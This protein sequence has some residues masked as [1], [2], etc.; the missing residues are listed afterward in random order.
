MN[1]I[2]APNRRE[3][4]WQRMH[5]L[6]YTT[7]IHLFVTQGY[8]TTTMDQI[9]ER[10]DVARATV[11]N[12]FVQKVG[13][14]EEWGARRRVRVAEILGR[15]HAEDMPVDERLRRY[16]H[17]MAELNTCSREESMVLME[18][19]ARFGRLWQDPSLE[20]DLANII[21]VGV[22]RGEI[23]ADLDHLP[24]AAL[25]AAA[26]FSVVLRWTTT[27]PPHFDLA[28]RLDRVLELILTGILDTRPTRVRCADKGG[29]G[30]F[31][32]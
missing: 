18:A 23:R 17:E 22:R 10:A 25:L 16:F 27:D 3:R 8:E 20:K 24:T 11:F 13:F 4:N 14:L 15:E 9:A 12:H 28:R 26:Y 21:E 7:A 29:S 5:D 1:V 30:T 2:S 31:F 32:R 19:S 6:L